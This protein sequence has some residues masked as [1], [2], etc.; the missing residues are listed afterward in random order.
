MHNRTARIAEQIQKELATILL[1]HN[2]EPLF[3]KTTITRVKVSP[4]FSSAKIFISI[5][6]EKDI[7]ETMMTLQRS[8]KSLRHTLAKS[9]NLRLTPKL[10]FTYDDTAAYAHKLTNLI[11]QAINSDSHH[12]TE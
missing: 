5:W 7:D 6:D 12:E 2:E 9:L 3:T 10:I 11:D 8:S 1:R 4:D